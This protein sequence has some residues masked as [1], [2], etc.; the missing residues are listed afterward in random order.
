M[1]KAQ[2]IPPS[3]NLRRIFLAFF[4]P[5]TTL[6]TTPFR[7]IQTLWNCRI[8]TDKNDK[9]FNR[10]TPSGAINSLSYWIFALNFSYFGRSGRTPYMGLGDY[11]LSAQFQNTLLSLNAYWKNSNLTV[12][13]GM[14]GWWAFHFLWLND[15]NS[16][17]VV[18]VMG[19]TLISTLF[20]ANTFSLQNYNVLGWMF[21]PMA[22]YGMFQEYWG[23]TTLGWI[24]ISFTSFTVCFIGGLLSLALTIIDGSLSPALSFF[25]AGIKL[26]THFL[27][28][29]KSGNAKESAQK[30]LKGIGFKAGKTKYKWPVSFR[31]NFRSIYYGILFFQFC[32][33]CYFLEIDAQLTWLTLAV[34]YLNAT[35]FRLM[36]DQS[37]LLMMVSLVNVTL[38][39]NSEVLLLPFYWLLI[40]PIPFLAGFPYLKTLDVVP[41]LHPINIK[42]LLTKME[43]F[44]A[45]VQC[46]QKI[47][48]AFKNPDG[49]F[50]KVFDGF[51]THLMLA[52][53]VCTTKQILVLPNQEAVLETNYPDAPEFW[54]REVNQVL[55]NI[56][57]WK[58]DFVVV[59][60]EKEIH[61]NE[62]WVQAGFLSLT[63]FDWKESSI[64]LG[65]NSMPK[66]KWWLLQ[67]PKEN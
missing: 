5:I 27:P 12:L 63:E 4:Y 66:P 14:F 34:F 22:L 8:L 7:L 54:G 24:L 15:T 42:P 39:Q 56:R 20:Y 9:V 58:T 10:F 67:P 51:K 32:F 17:W 45:P 23:I 38:I 21:F 50:H 46:E 35:Y 61:L 44:F 13:L 64:S 36:D 11:P 57:K 37:I 2:D 30:T 16:S 55:D 41:E 25:P 53:Y 6:F 33:A 49:E 62:K 18:L 28:N 47:L 59:Y 31:P 43:G 19:L 48:M 60:Q 65:E 40:S 26:L 29:L 1:N 52:Q 3:F